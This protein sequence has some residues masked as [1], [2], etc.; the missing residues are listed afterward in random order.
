[1][2]AHHVNNRLSPADIYPIDLDQRPAGYDKLASEPVFDPDKHLA[3]E[4]P[5]ETY[6]LTDF[7]YPEEVVQ[8]SPVDFAASS[9]FRVLSEEGV[10]ALYDVMKQVE[11]FSRSNP[12]IERCV[13]G[14]VYRSKFL[15]DL[16][17]SPAVTEF[18]SEI[19]GLPLMPHT[20]PHQLGH[21][22]YNPTE[23]G[24]NVDK[25]HVDTLRF[26]Y[27][28]FVTDPKENQGGA[29]QYFKGTKDEMAA[30]KAAGADVP[31]AKVIQPDI[32]AAGYAVLQQGNLVVHQAKGLTAPG[33]RITMV[34]GY[35]PL[36]PHAEDYLRYD[37]L[38]FADPAEIVTAEYAQ[39]V[40]HQVRR[41]LEEGLSKTEFK[42]DREAY[43]AWLSQL[44]S[45]LAEAADEIRAA[46]S[47]KMEHFG[48]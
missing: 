39:H 17:L 34:N 15:R 13:R 35:M 20:I 14:A 12:R 19:A 7:G 36:D 23:I 22:N 41:K 40:G 5:A 28:I 26:D 27:V 9:T 4:K 8:A 3:L 29:F 31:A 46:D 6:S 37:Q 10:A 25:W 2:D 48:D 44:S 38:L 1:M 43:A 42:A 45:Q 16:C 30:L 33:E 21:I 11:G 47:A 18:M 24:A 32:P